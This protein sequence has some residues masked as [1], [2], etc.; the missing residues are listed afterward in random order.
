MRAGAL[1]GVGL[2]A[3][4][5]SGRTDAPLSAPAQDGAVDDASS[6]ALPAD[7]ASSDALPAGEASTSCP[8]PPSY[9]TQVAPIIA[10]VCVVCHHPGNRAAGA[11]FATYQAVYDARGNIVA[12]LEARL[13]PPP[14]A[15]APLTAAQ[16]ETLLA[17]LGCGAPDN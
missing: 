7:D 8:S 10:S 4:A 14:T 9:A 5:C 11:S 15:P 1:A 13:M 2:L 3:A 16:R 17:W 6:D 12:Q